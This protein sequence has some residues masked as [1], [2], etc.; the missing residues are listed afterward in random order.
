[1]LVGLIKKGELCESYGIKKEWYGRCDKEKICEI[2]CQ[3]RD[4]DLYD[5]ERGHAR[6]NEECWCIMNNTLETKRIY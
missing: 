6:K 3:K 4:M 5:Y 1:M 2:E